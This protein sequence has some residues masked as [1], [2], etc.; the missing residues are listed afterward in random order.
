MTSRTGQRHG[1]CRWALAALLSFQGGE[2]SRACNL[3]PPVSLPSAAVLDGVI[4]QAGHRASAGDAPHCVPAALQGDP[5]APLI[6]APFHRNRW[7]R[8]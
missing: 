7:F 1:A 3:S 4:S 6:V 2:I 5:S 8:L